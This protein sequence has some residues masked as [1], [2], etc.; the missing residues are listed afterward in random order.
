MSIGDHCD[1][2]FGHA[3]EAS[4][5]SFPPARVWQQHDGGPRPIPSDQPIQYLSDG[6]PRPWGAYS[7]FAPWDR[8]TAYM[9]EEWTGDY[10][11]VTPFPMPRSSLARSLAA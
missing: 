3:E 11:D 4:V 6:N 9:V 1:I 10:A 5:L 2:E 8:I 7:D